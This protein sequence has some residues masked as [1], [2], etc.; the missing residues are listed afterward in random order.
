MRSFLLVL[1]TFLP[2][3]GADVIGDIEFFG[4]QGINVASIRAALRV[5]EGDAYSER[6]KDDV[7]RALG[8]AMGKQPTD[9]AAICGD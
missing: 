6:T 8:V 3:S 7:R 1:L 4:Y 5:H 2:A 9:V